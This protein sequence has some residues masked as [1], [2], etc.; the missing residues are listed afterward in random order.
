MSYRNISVV[1]AVLIA[2]SIYAHHKLSFDLAKAQAESPQNLMKS[3]ERVRQDMIVISRQL[4]VTCT[5]CHDVQ[6]F[7]NGE[8]K[9]YKVALEHMKLVSILKDHGMNGK[10]GPEADCYL[11]HRGKLMPDYKEPATNKK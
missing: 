7:K 3:E 9:T 11:C 6:N 5:E 10:T 8:K 2:L 4:G 1:L